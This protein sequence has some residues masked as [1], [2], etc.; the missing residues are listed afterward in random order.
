MAFV[1]GELEL[2]KER[3]G[4]EFSRTGRCGD[5]REDSGEERTAL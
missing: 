3:P 5:E 1:Q 4:G 2:V